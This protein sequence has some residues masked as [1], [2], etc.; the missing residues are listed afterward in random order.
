MKQENYTERKIREDLRVPG[1]GN[2]SKHYRIQLMVTPEMSMDLEQIHGVDINEEA[3]S[4]MR[5]Q[6]VMETCKKLTDELLT[7]EAHERGILDVA[8][9]ADLD[10]TIMV[11][12]KVASMIHGMSEFKASSKSGNRHI[13]R[14]GTLLDRPVYVNALLR[15]DE[16]HAFV[17]NE[18]VLSTPTVNDGVISRDD[19]TVLIIEGAY[20]VSKQTRNKHYII[21]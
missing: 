7:I 14:I 16:S 20:T 12:A 3:N 13:Y 18:N 10:S 15:Y 11:N 9:S 5:E 2:V 21:K 4:E 17:I 1:I 6:L 8:F 19:G